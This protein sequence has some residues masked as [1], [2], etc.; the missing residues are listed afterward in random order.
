M[1]CF[2]QHIDYDYFNYHPL[3]YD[4]QAIE[5]IKKPFKNC[6]SRINPNSDFNILKDD[7]F[8]NQGGLA[9]LKWDDGFKLLHCNKTIKNH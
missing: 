2:M 3:N 4:I 6:M 8:A 7:L 9:E 1:D 5:E